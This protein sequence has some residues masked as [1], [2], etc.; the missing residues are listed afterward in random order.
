MI[1]LI[2]LVMVMGLAIGTFWAQRDR[3]QVRT[4]YAY[5]LTLTSA[6]DLFELAVGRPPTTEEGLAALVHPPSGFEDR[7]GGPYIE[8][9]ATIIDLWGNEYQYMSPGRDGRRFDI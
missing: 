8:A 2:I 3:A 1:V 4:A 7:W 6:V 9:R 5:I